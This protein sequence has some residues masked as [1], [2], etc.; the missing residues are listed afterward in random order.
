[1]N[2][3][4]LNT[5]ESVDPMIGRASAG[6]LICNA[7]GQC[8]NVITVNLGICS[9]TKAALRGMDPSLDIAWNAGHR[10]VAIQSDF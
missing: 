9:I 8:S 7:L 4:I 3:V 10:R 2:G 1:M 5:D 6:G